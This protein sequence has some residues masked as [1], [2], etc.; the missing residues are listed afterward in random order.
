[1]AK[2]LTC[3]RTSR[4]FAARSN[5]SPRSWGVVINCGLASSSRGLRNQAGSTVLS[6]LS[7]RDELM[8]SSS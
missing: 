3:P 1:M 8:A 6:E 5:A 4:R 2:Y 7:D